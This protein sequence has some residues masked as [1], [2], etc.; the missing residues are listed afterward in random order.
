MKMIQWMTMRSLL[1]PRSRLKSSIGEKG[2][3]TAGRDMKSLPKNG[4]AIAPEGSPFQGY[5]TQF[6]I[7]AV[8]KA[9]ISLLFQ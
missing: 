8:D 1:K 4:M 5:L 9:R 7:S 2:K 3:E 6:W